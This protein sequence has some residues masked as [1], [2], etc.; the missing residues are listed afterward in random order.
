[1]V[2]PPDDFMLIPP[3]SFLNDCKTV[4][5]ELSESELAALGR[6]LHLLLETNKQFNLTAIT[7]PEAAW[8]R[9]I[10]ESLS[11]MPHL[12]SAR[13]IIDVGSGGGLPGLPLAIALPAAS[14]QVT[15]LEATG[16]KANFLKHI[17]E[18]MGLSHVRVVNE[19]AE[20]VGQDAR[21]RQQFDAAVSR[22]VG[23]MNVLL[24]FSM[25][26]V[27]MNGKMLAMKGAKAGEELEQSTDAM[28]ILGGGEIEIYEALPGLEDDAVIVEI[29][30]ARPTP[31][32]YPR[33][34]GEPKRVPL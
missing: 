28:Q 34:N 31:K 18:E 13:T 23:A 8:R 7:D 6:Y 5:L 29:E 4:G 26:L 12:A 16:K 3:E 19:R 1:M 25:P 22:A 9:H 30:K 11:F 2:P 14:V 10:L 33:R 15:L 32:T 20:V 27:R 24:E 17:A 21:Y